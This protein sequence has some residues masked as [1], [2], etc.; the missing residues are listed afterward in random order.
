MTPSTASYIPSRSSTPQSSQSAQIQS[1]PPLGPESKSNNLG[2][3]VVRSEQ[4]TIPQMLTGDSLQPFDP[5]L[6]AGPQELNELPQIKE[7]L[8]QA[9]R[10]LHQLVREKLPDVVGELYRTR[11]ELRQ[12]SGELHEAKGELHQTRGELHQ[13]RRES[14]QVREELHRVREERESRRRGR[15]QMLEP[16]LGSFN[17]VEERRIEMKR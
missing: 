14:H 2:E 7:E 5:A 15:M 6:S 3:V 16:V 17:S 12:T 11:G 9:R 13:V 10:E 1:A 8:H 4:S